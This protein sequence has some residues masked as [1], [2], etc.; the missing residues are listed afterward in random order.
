MSATD[1]VIVGL[2]A[3]AGWG[4]V[5]VII[6]VIRQQKRPPVSFDAPSQPP[7]AAPPAEGADGSRRDSG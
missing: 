5:S 6:T 7:Q 4:I 1:W 3:L 2:A